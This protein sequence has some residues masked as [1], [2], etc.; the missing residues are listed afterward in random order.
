MHG[1]NRL[2]AVGLVLSLALS[3]CTA[4]GQRNQGGGPSEPAV[5]HP[6]DST[7]LVGKSS[8]QRV[9]PGEPAPYLQGAITP[10][11]P[12]LWQTNGQG[13]GPVEGR[14]FY[15]NPASSQVRT[16]EPALYSAVNPL[17]LS[18]AFWN[19]SAL[20]IDKQGLAEA[21]STL[22][23]RLVDP[24]DDASFFRLFAPVGGGVWLAYTNGSGLVFERRG[25]ST[26]RTVAG[27]PNSEPVPLTGLQ[28]VLIWQQGDTAWVLVQYFRPDNVDA[29]KQVSRVAVAQ[30]QGDTT[31]WTIPA[32]ESSFCI[33][34]NP[35]KATIIGGTVYLGGKGDL[36][37]FRLESSAVEVYS[38]GADLGRLSFDEWDD[39]T[40]G[41]ILGAWRDILLV[42]YTQGGNRSVTWAIRGGQVLGSLVIDKSRRTV[43]A[44]SAQG[45]HETP[46]EYEIDWE[47][48][49]LPQAGSAN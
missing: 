20:L 36:A 23:P 34:A 7:G 44:H 49:L 2:A 22:G 17:D 6:V 15:W 27:F 31:T 21:S 25:A 28:P 35:P 11:I 37:S 3:G 18:H 26:I 30:I 32:Q 5:Q 42:G 4:I 8:A 24:P 29:N 48:P 41:P 1:L 12:L 40:G 45:V 33:D 46:L 16:K 19:G 38:L 47:G 14:V 10:D 39:S 9:T 43:Q 13:G